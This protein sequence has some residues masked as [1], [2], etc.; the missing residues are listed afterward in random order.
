MKLGVIQVSG[1]VLAAALLVA[2]TST[3]SLGRSA[4]GAAGNGSP[5]KPD[6]A[7]VAIGTKVADWQLSHMD[8]FDYVPAGQHREHTERRRDWIQAAFYIGLTHFA[9]L[10]A[11]QRYVDAVLAHGAAEGWGF[12]DRPRHADSDATAA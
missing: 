3:P 6:P 10:V 1:G 9:D 7:V 8:K 12:D 11:K 4:A 5:R 2:V